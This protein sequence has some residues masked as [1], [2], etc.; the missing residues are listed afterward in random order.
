VPLARAQ[1]APGYGPIGR[2]DSLARSRAQSGADS[3]VG[4][5]LTAMP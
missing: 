4:T 5:A 3:P 1:D 2:S